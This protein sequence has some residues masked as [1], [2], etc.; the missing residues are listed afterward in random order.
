MHHEIDCWTICLASSIL[1]ESK[2]KINKTALY[3]S[4]DFSVGK[5]FDFMLGARIEKE[6]DHLLHNPYFKTF[7][8]QLIAEETSHK[9]H[10]GSFIGI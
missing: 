7:L 6:D 2:T 4:D 10:Q 8:S 1:V 3:V 9:M 5:I